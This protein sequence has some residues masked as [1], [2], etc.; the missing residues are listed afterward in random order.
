MSRVAGVRSFEIHIPEAELTE[1]RARLAATRGF[2]DVF[3]DDA[4]YGAPAAFV[5]GL[6]DHWLSRFD[7]RAF[8]T[9]VNDTPQITTE[10]DGL[11]LHALHRR[12]RRADALPLILLHGWPGSFID[13]LEVL[14][15]F[16]DPPPHEPAF[17]VVVPSLPGHGFSTTRRGITPR[18]IAAMLRE[19]MARLGYERYLVQGG[20][21]GSPI[22]AE[23]ALQAPE[24]VMGL[25]LN[26]INGAAP[27]GPAD[28]PLSAEEQA[29]LAKP[30]PTSL[31]H[32]L[33]FSRAP[34][35][36]AY[37][38]NDSPAGLIAF[39]GERLLDWSDRR[40]G[41]GLSADFMVATAALYW[42]T[43]TS[44]SSALL[45]YEFQR[46][47][48]IEG[49]VSVPTAVALFA[50]EFV[51]IPRSWA[52][53][54]FNIVQWRLF[55]RGGKFPAAEVGGTFVADVRGFAAALADRRGL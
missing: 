43:R 7:W 5:R 38:L 47:A 50:E 45:Y 29:W 14:V 26:S 17:H 22:G 16:T 20:N 55:E 52:E 30:P 3:E 31:P 4:R 39:I 11:T 44:G 53:C 40:G 18:R 23:I 28:P 27:A 37:A 10:I 9:R 24:R 33:L 54:H 48:P 36:F 1:V 42:F 32:Y 19:L 21:W 13:F 8:E 6:C 35:S 51:R 15:P 49:Y 12:S 25:H 2:D 34:A 41:V 46:D